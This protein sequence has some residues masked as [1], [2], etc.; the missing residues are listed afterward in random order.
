MHIFIELLASTFNKDGT[1]PTLGQ[2]PCY[3]ARRHDFSSGL[4][5]ESYKK[6][7]YFS[8]YIL[9]M[10]CLLSTIHSIDMIIHLKHNCYVFKIF[11]STMRLKMSFIV[12]LI[13]H[14]AQNPVFISKS[15]LHIIYLI[16]L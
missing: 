4:E 9:V 16:Q 13:M 5:I 14:L 6:S 10:V 15:I 12:F 8:K 1:Y 2:T 3:F 11:F 7:K